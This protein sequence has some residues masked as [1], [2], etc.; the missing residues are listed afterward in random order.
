[1]E[2]EKGET[3]SA[4]L[5]SCWA[6][7]QQLGPNRWRRAVQLGS[8]VTSS[9]PGRLFCRPG[10]AFYRGV[11]VFSTMKGEHLSGVKDIS[12]NLWKWGA[13]A[14]PP[15]PHCPGEEVTDRPPGRRQG[16]QWPKGRCQMQREEWEMLSSAGKGALWSG[17]CWSELLKPQRAD[18]W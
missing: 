6:S 5:S 9:Q 16:S 13:A 7:A 4:P 11:R 2:G 15:E 12:N 3:R 10:V 17:P 14:G 8:P 18:G 1:M